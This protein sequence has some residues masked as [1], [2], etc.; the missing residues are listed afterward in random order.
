MR[1]SSRTVLRVAV[2]LLGGAMGAPGTAHAIG[3]SS[4]VHLSQLTLT[5]GT[6]PRAKGLAALGGEIRRRTNISVAQGVHRVTVTSAQLKRRPLLFTTA[7][8]A[9][10][11]LSATAVVKLRSHLARGGTWILDGPA[12]TRGAT[13]FRA[14]ARRLA[15]QLYPKLKLAA[16]LPSHTLFKSFYLLDPAR[17][18]RQSVPVQAVVRDGRAVLVVVQGL[19]AAGGGTVVG[20]LRQWL[21]RLT[22]N[23]VMYALCVDYKSDQVHAPT[24]LR[25]RRW[26]VP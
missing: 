7:S 2:L 12:S 6:A 15:Q 16:L 13:A 4:K 22:V 3:P 11:R 21:Y 17:F 14:S 18:A 20:R 1:L 10:P 24:I 8:G 5:G 19:S 23:L 9:L 26:R 25:R